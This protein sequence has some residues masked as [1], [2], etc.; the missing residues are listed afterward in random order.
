ML[1]LRRGRE[2]GGV[3]FHEPREEERGVFT[4]L[5][6]KWRV[7]ESVAE[8]RDVTVAVNSRRAAGGGICSCKMEEF[9]PQLT[10]TG[11]GESSQDDSK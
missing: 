4:R 10:R 2:G 6:R 3:R 1:F 5:G 11:R 8:K 7:L 9:V